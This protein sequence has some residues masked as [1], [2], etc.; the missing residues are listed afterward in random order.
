MEI[1]DIPEP[2]PG[3]GQVKIKVMASGICGSD[4]HIQDSNIGIPVRTPVVT[5]HE[6]SG[7][8]A[9]VG[10]GVTDWKPGDRVV[11]ETAYAYCGK[12]EACRE[13]WYNL[14]PERKT[15]GYWYNGIFTNYT[16]VPEGRVHHMPD[17]IDFVS[18]AMTE[19]L[20]CVC[21]AVFD[22]TEIKPTDLVLVNGPGPMGLLTVMVVKSFG[23]KVLVSGTKVDAERLESAKELGADYICNIDETPLEECVNQLTGGYG[24]DV[25]MEC[26]GN[27][28]G[29][30]GALKVLK[31]RGY[32]T[33]I[34]MGKPEIPFYV[35]ALN[36]REPHVT[37]SL[38]SRKAS[39]EQALDLL[40]RG[41]VKMDK[42]VSHKMPLAEWE[43]AFNM[44]R[45]KEGVKF[46]LLP[47]EEDY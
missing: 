19:P 13:G 4:L 9:E 26:S 11:S 5:G 25:V 39:W 8:V 36:Y 2:T 34:G 40:A 21:H 20:A 42:I 47:F 24:V 31:R 35:T 44:F 37:G 27:Q 10:E 33:M 14:C 16:I 23:A 17:N 7:I 45:A 46:V 3:P 30:N 15:L 43:T 29:I 1:R 12:C 32:F 22:L 41:K 18:A 28:Y 6:F 38:G